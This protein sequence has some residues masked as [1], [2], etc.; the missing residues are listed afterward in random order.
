MCS[1]RNWFISYQSVDEGVV[2]MGNGIPCKTIGFGSIRI[3]MF[4]GIVRELTDVRYVPEHKSNLISLRVLDSCGYKYAGQ[5][6]TLT[7][8]TGSLVVMK[9]TKVDNIYKVEGSTEVAYEVTDVS[10]CL[11]QKYQGHKSKKELQILVSGKSF[12]DLKYLFMNSYLFYISASYDG[13]IK[14]CCVWD[15]TSHKVIIDR[16]IVCMEQP[17]GLIQDHNGKFVCMLDNS[18]YGLLVP[19]KIYKRFESFIASHNFSKGRNDYTIYSTFTVL[20]LFVDDMLDASRSMDKISKK[21]TQ[22]DR[23]I[24]MRDQGAAKQIMGMKVYRDG[25]GKL[26]L[27]FNINIIKPVFIPLSFHYKFYSSIGPVYKEEKVMSF[28]S[29]VGGLLYVMKWLR[30]YVSHDNDVVIYVTDS[31]VVVKWV[32]KH[33]RS[34]NVTYNGYTEMVCDNCNVYFTGVLDRRRYI[35]K[36]VSKHRCGKHVG[37]GVTPQEIQTRA[38]HI[39]EIMKPVLLEKL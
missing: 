15:P 4:D 19:R 28:V 8:L 5:G 30:P 23:T 2:F 9:E 7:L 10:S 34:T 25:N 31:G 16:D 38:S 36:Y 13:C 29:L 32:L 6:G 35:T 12:L 17:K 3:R 22:V 14:G 20:M 11:W 39:G 18:L 21:M 33:L 37:G 27:E 26:W 24:Q 1:H